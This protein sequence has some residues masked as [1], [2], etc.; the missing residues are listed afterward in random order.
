[1][2]TMDYI[3]TDVPAGLGLREWRLTQITPRRRRLRIGMLR[4]RHG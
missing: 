4:R 1:M 3:H 2:Q